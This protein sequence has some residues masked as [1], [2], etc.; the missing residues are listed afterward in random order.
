M[1]NNPL[2]E[3]NILLHFGG[4]KQNSLSRIL[5]E[6]ENDFELDTIGHSKYYN[7]E[8]L[9]SD[10]QE[11]AANLLVLSLNAQSILAKFSSYE[12]MLQALF[13]QDIRPDILLIQESW[14]KNDDFL[15]LVQ[16]DGYTCISQG[17]KCSRH[18]GLITYINSKFST[19]I[20]DI[21]PDSQIWEGLF[22]E[23]SLN[24]NKE[25]KY[26]I[27]NIYKP[28]RDNNNY[29]NIQNFISEFDPVLNYLNRSKTECI[30]G[31]D[32]NINLLKINERPAFSDF[33]DL[34]FN[35]SLGPKITL[36]TRFA[37]RSAS[38][39]D[40]I[41]CKISDNS[42]D[43]LAGIIYTGVS[44]HLPYFVC[45]R[46]AIKRKKTLPKYVKCKINKP[47]AIRKFIEELQVEKYIPEFRS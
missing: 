14:L 41:Y 10:I 46:N 3:E 9:P 18:G 43:S 8:H 6:I 35:N 19:K 28:P 38:L 32:W 4:T 42:I 31:G 26:I 36:P 33:I 29:Q 21:C 2:T 44:D 40:N 34:M 11:N 17:Y 37:S 16:I 15:H 47:E 23:I 39:I 13:E 22:V 24:D 27:G 20:L 45:L 30:I 12:I 5:Q 7:L 25:I 1:D